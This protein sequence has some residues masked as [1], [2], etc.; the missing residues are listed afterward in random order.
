MS[1]ESSSPVTPFLLTR[2]TRL[3]PLSMVEYDEM[4]QVNVV[5]NGDGQVVPAVTEKPYLA[6]TVTESEEG[7]ED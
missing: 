3:R 5:R 1:A 6:K 2:V 4:L 7:G